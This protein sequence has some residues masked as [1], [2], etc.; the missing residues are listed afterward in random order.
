VELNDPLGVGVRHDVTLLP[1]EGTVATL[2][3]EPMLSFFSQ[4]YRKW[5]L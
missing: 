5:Q 2:D 1:E 4:K 3:L